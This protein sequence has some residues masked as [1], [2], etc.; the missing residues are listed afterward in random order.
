MSRHSGR[1]APARFL[2]TYLRCLFP[3]TYPLLSLLHPSPILV[4]TIY[5]YVYALLCAYSLMS[6]SVLR[7]TYP[8][9]SMHALVLILLFLCAPSTRMSMRAPTLY[10]TD[11]SYYLLYGYATPP[12]TL[13]ST[14][15]VLVWLPS[16]SFVLCRLSS[17][18][19]AR[20]APIASARQLLMLVCTMYVS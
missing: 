7:N 15:C 2:F 5:S 12:H 18:A 9:I 4:P 8:S 10:H 14:T 3:S 1:S 17:L 20:L 19:L 6:L 13:T 16:W 11:T